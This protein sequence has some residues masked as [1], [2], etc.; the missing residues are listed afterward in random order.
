MGNQIG[1]TT[2]VDDETESVLRG[3]FAQVCVE[4]DMN[5]PLILC[6]C[7][8]GPVQLMEYEGFHVICFQCG[9]YGHRN[10]NSPKG[11]INGSTYPTSSPL[12]AG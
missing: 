3:Q 2:K 5:K 1:K 8:M 7:L 10:E 11:N 4:V 12:A 9:Q 6:V